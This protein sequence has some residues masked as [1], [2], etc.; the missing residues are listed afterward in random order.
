[1][2]LLSASAG[3]RR[4]YKC[5]ENLSNLPVARLATCPSL[6]YRDG[7]GEVFSFSQFSVLDVMPRRLHQ[8]SLLS[9]KT[10][11]RRS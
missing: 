11:L 3:V 7:D 8:G 10:S 5:A 4:A 9:R 1:M 6:L 2:H